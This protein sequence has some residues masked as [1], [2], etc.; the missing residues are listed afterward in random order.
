MCAGGCDTGPLSSEGR[1]RGECRKQNGGWAVGKEV[2]AG[3][4]S[5]WVEGPE[6]RSRRQPSG[7]PRIEIL[8][9]APKIGCRTSSLKMNH[10]RN[11][12]RG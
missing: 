6:G 4:E 8:E 7:R 10:V 2:P 12:I 11:Q 5:E 1:T 9:A 3:P